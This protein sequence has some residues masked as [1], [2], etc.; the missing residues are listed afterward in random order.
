M[1]LA[2]ESLI[3][4]C[5]WAASESRWRRRGRRRPLR[6]VR[7]HQPGPRPRPPRDKLQPTLSRHRSIDDPRHSALYT[8]EDCGLPSLVATLDPG[9]SVAG[10]PPADAEAAKSAEPQPSNAAPQLTLPKGGGA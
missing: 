9:L 1:P 2:A 3:T 4:R 10:K 8:P 6:H 7:R 5:N